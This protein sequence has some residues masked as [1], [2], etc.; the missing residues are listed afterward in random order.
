MKKCEYEKLKKAFVESFSF[1]AQNKLEVKEKKK[2]KLYKLSF[3][4]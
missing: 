1:A 4:P 2:R 3:I